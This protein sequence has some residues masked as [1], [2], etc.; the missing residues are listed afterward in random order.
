[1]A[2]QKENSHPNSQK[3][4]MQT[5]RKKC[6]SK[7]TGSVLRCKTEKRGQNRNEITMLFNNNDMVIFLYVSMIISILLESTN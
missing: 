7:T 6:T 3:N 4:A 2:V 1:M 5:A